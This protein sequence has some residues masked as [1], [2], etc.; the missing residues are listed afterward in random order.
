VID[1]SENPFAELVAELADGKRWTLL[2]ARAGTT[3]SSA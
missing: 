3:S 2:R 1:A